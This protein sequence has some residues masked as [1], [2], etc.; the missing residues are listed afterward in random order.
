MIGQSAGDAKAV[1]PGKGYIQ[2]GKLIRVGG[3]EL[4]GRWQTQIG[5]GQGQGEV[6]EEEEEGDEEEE[7][8]PEIGFPRDYLWRVGRGT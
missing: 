4:V 1:T 3:D 8:K 2:D 7:K 5:L 6:F